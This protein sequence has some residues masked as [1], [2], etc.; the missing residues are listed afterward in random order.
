MKKLVLIILCVLLIGCG[1]SIDGHWQST[2][3]SSEIIFD[4]DKVI[5]FGVE[6]SFKVSFGKIIMS[7]GSKELTYEYDLKEDQLTL[8]LDDGE[9]VLERIK[10]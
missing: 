1:R 3:G 4:D 7:F 8:Y 5:F 10:Q 6:G 9:V 2:G